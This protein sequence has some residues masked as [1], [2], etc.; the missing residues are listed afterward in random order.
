M[1][2]WHRPCFSYL[3]AGSLESWVRVF[4]L[5]KVTKPS[6]AQMRRLELQGSTIICS[7]GTS[8]F[9]KKAYTLVAVEKQKKA[10]LLEGKGRRGPPSLCQTHPSLEEGS[11]SGTLKGEQCGPGLSQRG[12][13]WDS[14][15]PLRTRVTS[16]TWG[17][18]APSVPGFTLYT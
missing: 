17:A 11:P 8:T 14:P 6:P 12:S 3:Q 13:S 7:Q 15:S 4:L 10:V 5:P 18:L 9:Q 16:S 2:G 1:P